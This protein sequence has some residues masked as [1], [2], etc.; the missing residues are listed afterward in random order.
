MHMVSEAHWAVN[1]LAVLPLWYSRPA[2][3]ASPR[4]F[5]PALTSHCTHHRTSNL[6]TDG[7]NSR[8]SVFRPGSL[9]WICREWV[10]KLGSDEATAYFGDEKYTESGGPT[11][12]GKRTPRLRM[13]TP[14][15]SR[16][17]RASLLSLGFLFLPPPLSLGD[18][19]C[20]ISLSSVHP[21]PTLVSHPCLYLSAH[22]I[23][24]SFWRFV[25]YC[26]PH[27]T[28]QGLRPR[29]WGQGVSCGYLIR[30]WHLLRGL[31]FLPCSYGW[32]IGLGISF[33][34][35]KGTASGD[36]APSSPVILACRGQGRPR[37]HILAVW[38]PFIRLRALLSPRHGPWA[39]NGMGRNL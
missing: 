14:N 1:R 12:Q 37:Q 16:I 28:V 15:S 30:R 36:M 29:Q 21:P 2:T 17:P 22:P 3:I 32:P 5:D 8:V 6:P 7:A 39:W 27:H 13:W 20:Y 33:G 11:S 10:Q 25:S 18:L 38:I 9:Q 23:D 35:L 24:H 4:E 19:C 26:G 34:I 31:L